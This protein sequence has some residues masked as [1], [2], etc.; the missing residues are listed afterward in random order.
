MRWTGIRTVRGL[1]VL[2]CVSLLAFLIVAAIPGDPAVNVLGS[3][4]TPQ[5][6]AAL[7]KEMGLD[8]GL[9]SRYWEWLSGVFHFNFGTT[10]TG[11]PE[12][13]SRVIAGSAPI[14]IEISVLAAVISLA[15][16]IA[17]GCWAASR[18]G[19]RVDQGIGAFSFG[20][21]ALP[22]FVVA[23]LLARLFVFDNAGMK[24]AFLVIGIASSAAAVYSLAGRGTLLRPSGLWS[25]V[26]ALLG[27]LL[28]LFLPVFPRQGWVA[29]TASPGQNLLHAL[30]PSL[31]IALGL[32]PLYA[33]V[34]STELKATLSSDFVAMARVRGM[35]PGHVLFKEALRPSLFSLT[36]VTG[37]SLGAIFAGSAITETLFGLPGLG[38]AIVTSVTANDYPLIQALVL[39]VAVV[40]TLLNAFADVLYIW[41]DPRTR[42]HAY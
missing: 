20:L 32:I 16:G 18:P 8:Q 27:V 19:S 30:L 11:T 12:P 24:V 37:V 28:Y 25:L 33:Q 21:I 36:T 3:D 5:A 42:R 15:G 17:L 10:L 35:S 29:L 4:A 23:I 13:V 31:S 39:V 7:R 22:T 38:S 26:P 14:T 2:W 41:L 1:L 6:V 9:W 40:Y 34:L